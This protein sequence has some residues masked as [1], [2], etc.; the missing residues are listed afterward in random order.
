MVMLQ[1]P[2]T[3]FGWIAGALDWLIEKAG[4]LMDAIT[5]GKDTLSDAVGG[6]IGRFIPGF[7]MGGVVPGPVGAPRLALVHG[8]ET[9]LPTHKEQAPAA[10]GSVTVPVY[11]DGVQIAKV[12]APLLAQDR[13]S[14]SGTR[15]VA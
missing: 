4:D 13:R 15:K 14:R 9:I 1:A 3:V 5:I 2:A 10:S 12:V 11:L 8:G 7:D 6:A